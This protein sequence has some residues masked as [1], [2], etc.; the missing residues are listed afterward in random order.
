MGEA[1]NVLTL[2][3]TFSTFTD[4]SLRWMLARQSQYAVKL[5]ET[6]YSTSL[7]RPCSM[8][9]SLLGRQE[10]D[11]VCRL[12]HQDGGVAASG[13]MCG[14]IMSVYYA[15]DRMSTEVPEGC[16]GLIGNIP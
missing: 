11:L 9:K 3:P 2:H 4:L 8:K 12:C 7:R 13:P 10:G 14:V 6:R 1:Q 5:C 15:M 16:N